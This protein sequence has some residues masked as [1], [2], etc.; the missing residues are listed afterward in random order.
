MDEELTV[1]LSRS[2][3]TTGFGFSLLGTAGLPHVIYDILENSPAADS[4]KVIHYYYYYSA[5][6][7][8]V[9]YNIRYR[10]VLFFLI[11]RLDIARTQ[12]I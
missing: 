5:A 4:G 2:D 12:N 7:N 6:H 9:M 3:S 11:T 10:P 1:T 8:N